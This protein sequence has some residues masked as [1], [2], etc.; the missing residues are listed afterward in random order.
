MSTCRWVRRIRHDGLDGGAFEHSRSRRIR[1][2]HL[3]PDFGPAVASWTRAQRRMLGLRRPNLRARGLAASHRRHHRW[4]RRHVS[5]RRR[6]RASTRNTLKPRS[7]THG[8]SLGASIGRVF[9]R[10]ERL[11]LVDVIVDPDGPCFAAASTARTLWVEVQNASSLSDARIANGFGVSGY[12]MRTHLRRSC[13]PA[14]FT[15]GFRPLSPTPARPA[16]RGQSDHMPRVRMAESRW[17]RTYATIVVPS[18]AR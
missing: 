18:F 8:G 12:G 1:D 7:S 17:L 6:V 14:H 10:Q 16:H 15:C 13:R 5:R 3:R 4:R 11:T 9:V 2:L